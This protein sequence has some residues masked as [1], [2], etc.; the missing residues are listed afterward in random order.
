MRSADAH[1]TPQEIEQL[2]FGADDS[3]DNAGG[4]AA[5]EAQQHLSGC[6]VCQSVADK[7]RNVDLALKGLRTDDKWAL[8]ASTRGTDCP[9]DETWLNL[10]AGLIREEEAARY[11]SHA[12]QCDWCGPLLKESMEDLAQP[13]TTEEQ[14]V[15]DK[16]PSASP[17]WQRAMAKKMAAAS[18]NADVPLVEVETPARNKEPESKE[19]SGFAW[20]PKLVWA[21][22][23]FAVLVVGV[24]VGVR[25]TREPDVNTLLAQAYI[26]RHQRVIELR[27]QGA[28]YGPSPSAERGT[29]K[30]DLS[31]SFYS[32][33]GIIKRKLSEHPQDPYWLQARARA[34][35]LEGDYEAANSYLHDA[36]QLKPKDS[37]LLLDEATALFEKAQHNPS[38]R[39]FYGKA[40][41]DLGEVL[42]QDHSNRVAL[43]NRAI[44]YTDLNSFDSSISDLNQFLQ[45]EPNGPWADEARSRLDELKKRLQRHDQSRAEPLLRPDE[46]VRRVRDPEALPQ[47]DSRIEDYQD[48]A[49]ANW[50]PAA[51]PSTGEE[52]HE[53]LSALRTLAG[54]LAK[55]HKDKWLSDFLAASNRS[56][57]FGAAVMALHDAVDRSGKGQWDADLAEAQK[58][59]ELFL[60]AGSIPGQ[61]RAAVEEVHA[62]RGKQQGK[63]CLQWAGPL[64]AKLKILAYRWI[65]AQTQIDQCSCAGMAGSFDRAESY[66][67]AAEK[68]TLQAGYPTLR[69]RAI[70]IDASA[71]T[72]AGRMAASWAKNEQGLQEYWQGS[73]P[74]LRAQ[75]FYDDLAVSAE[76]LEQWNLAVAF[77]QESAHAMSL[78]ADR[79]TEA[80]VRRHLTKLAIQAGNFDLGKEELKRSDELLSAL[81][82]QSAAG[83]A[84]SEIDRAQID[85]QQGNLAEAE[86]RL[87]AVRAHLDQF[88]NFE[89]L[90]DFY[91]TYAGLLERNGRIKE[92]ADYFWQAIKTADS[93]ADNLSSIPDRYL[94]NLEVS[95]LYRSLVGLKMR[96]NEDARALEIWEW[97]RAAQLPRSSRSLAVYNPFSAGQSLDAMFPEDGARAIVSY[98]VLPHGLAIWVMHDHKVEAIFERRETGDLVRLSSHLTGLCMNPD[99][100][101][102]LLRQEARQ[103]YMQ[104]IAPIAG[105]IAAAKTLAIESDDLLGGLPFEVLLSPDDR[106][107]AESYSIAYFPGLLYGIHLQSAGSL[108]S[109]SRVVALG[110]TATLNN[111]EWSLDPIPEVQGEAQAIAD[112]FRG[113]VALKGKDASIDRVETLLP[114]AEIAHLAAHGIVTSQ[115]EGLLLFAG[116]EAGVSASDTVLWDAARVRPELFQRAKLVVLSACS[117]DPST[118]NRLEIHG[119]LVRAILAARVPNVVASR[120]NVDSKLTARFMDEFYSQLI[121][122]R[123][124]SSALALAEEEIREKLHREHPYYWAAFAVIGRG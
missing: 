78:T 38:E 47:I 34:S 17:G 84:Y 83:H 81:Y 25:L 46:F 80:M 119:G 121:H 45:E 94:W 30:Q 71:D 105:R 108:S 68:A 74:P 40:V 76:E 55:R 29:G 33:L 72:L 95:G 51:F 91:S 107:L 87:N 96:Q 75:Q 120:W 6:A 109:H 115:S 43:F 4:G 112:K 104:L 37:G 123:S 59:K 3:K 21:G 101:L 86:R 66:I 50:L 1:L 118:K 14:E 65:D 22:S 41:E 57:V 111:D 90:L 93:N 11:V 69:L 110:S 97:H 35:L 113:G 10:A 98:A 13:V 49:I 19:Q 103:L 100:D 20:W 64:E 60:K 70:G 28:P 16:L 54:I 42:S 53:S 7:Y 39:H 82:D 122:G 124:A 88:T 116:K 18:G 26:G 23:G 12:A 114:Q 102:S 36:L 99:S 44:I 52:S 117:S 89:I 24:L 9:D 2:L 48:E 63:I 58:A 27:M 77:G 5:P 31:A 61:L 56:Q 15:L 32:A 67:K 106:Y 79:E 73:S 8:K 62:Q 92:A 85:V